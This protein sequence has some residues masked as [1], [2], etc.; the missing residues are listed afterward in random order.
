MA[1]LLVPYRLVD[2]RALPRDPSQGSVA[3]RLG[4]WLVE[5]TLASHIAFALAMHEGAGG[6]LLTGFHEFLVARVG[7]TTAWWWPGLTLWLTEPVGAKGRG[8]GH[9]PDEVNRAAIK[10]WYELLDDHLPARDAVEMDGAADADGWEQPTDET[11]NR[12]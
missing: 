7:V 6:D 3:S 10:R 1:R 2:D 12:P 4:G 9:L 8:F 5:D 11:G